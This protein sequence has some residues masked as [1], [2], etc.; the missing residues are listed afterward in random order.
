VSAAA[1]VVFWL[2]VAAVAYAQ[3]GY[4]GCLAALSRLIRRPIKRAPIRPSVSLIIPVH[5]AKVLIDRKIENLR[6][7]DYPAELLEII[8]VDDCSTDDTADLAGVDLSVGPALRLLCRN[9]RSGKAG[10]LNAAL[11]RARGE[12]M[13]FTDVAAMLEPDALSLAVEGFAD[14][15]VGCV[16]SEDEVI[17][18]DGAAASEGLYTRIDGRIRALESEVCSATG[19]NGSFYLARRE[20]CP[21]FPLDVATDMFTALHCVDRGFRAVVDERSK[22][23]LTAQASVGREFERKVRTM[24]TGLRAQRAFVRLLNPFRAGVFSVFL[25]SHKLLRYLTPVFVAMAVGSTAYLSS[26]S[27]AFRYL[28]WVELGAVCIG[29][30]QILMQRWTARKGVAGVPAFLCV[31]TAAAVAG[32]YRYLRG[33]RYE[34]WQPTERSPV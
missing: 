3:V 7:L 15:T 18:G 28:L 23:H 10:A 12:I 32:W 25:V 8:V 34:T 21:P 1:L 22:V 24:V 6:G 4:L 9:R 13:G 29:M 5:N 31:T 20:L 11:E 27:A 19:M 33:D 2:S 17:V 14:P 16:S 26:S 30:A